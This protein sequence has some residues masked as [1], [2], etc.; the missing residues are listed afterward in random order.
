MKSVLGDDEVGE[1]TKILFQTATTK[2]MD[3][4]YT[5]N[6]KSFFEFCAIS[7]LEPPKNVP[8]NIARYITWLGKR[9][10]VADASL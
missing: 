8:I 5:S 4:N 7:L 9:E 2:G 6:L 10:T 1:A 3:E